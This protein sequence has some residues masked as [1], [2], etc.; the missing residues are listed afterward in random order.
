MATLNATVDCALVAL[1]PR[2]PEAAAQ[3]AG[4]TLLAVAIGLAI[5]F[6]DP[7]LGAGCLQYLVLVPALALGALLT[8]RPGRLGFGLGYSITV[9]MLAYPGGTG[10]SGQAGY[11][12][13]AA[14]L[15]VSVVVLMVV[16]A[17]LQR[18][19]TASIPSA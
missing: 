9:C 18:V 4:G 3:M 17:A 15:V 19:R 1:A 8:G 10:I 6:I 11:L 7:V 12:H 5:R 13:D 16:S 2:P 14:G